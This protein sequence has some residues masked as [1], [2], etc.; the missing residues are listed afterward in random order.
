MTADNQSVTQ[1]IRD[2]LIRP[3]SVFR[4]IEILNSTQIFS[5]F[6][7]IIIINFLFLT[8]LTGLNESGNNL[9]VIRV[10]NS[11][12]FTHYLILI[13]DLVLVIGFSGCWLHM[14]IRLFGGKNKMRQTITM[15][16]YSCTP[17]ILFFWVPSIL[18]KLAPENCISFLNQNPGLFWIS[19]EIF[20]GIWGCFLIVWGIKELTGFSWIRSGSLTGCA[21]IVP[22]VCLF[23]Y[24]A[25][26]MTN[27]SNPVAYA[28]PRIKNIS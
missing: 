2:M 5:F 26:I 19:I 10:F 8:L 25:F 14:W 4:S 6:C 21:I 16:L 15:V 12:F 20:F 7:S 18:V 28:Y 9:D 22:V 17:V 11:G 13:V 27:T 23:C 1:Q 24:N 3:A